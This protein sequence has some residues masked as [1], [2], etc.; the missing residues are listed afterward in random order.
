[1]VRPRPARQPRSFHLSS[2]LPAEPE[3]GAPLPISP[4]SQPVLDFLALRRSASA[5]TLGGPPPSADELR[6]LLRL[7]AR[8]P[9]HGKLNPWRFVVLEGEAKAAFA[10]GLETI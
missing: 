5:G 3:F 4:A 10:A 9:D 8:V 1:M 2:R 7:A 6:D